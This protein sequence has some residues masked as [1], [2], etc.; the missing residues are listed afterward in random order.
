M[1]ISS[2]RKFSGRTSPRPIGRWTCLGSVSW[3]ASKAFPTKLKNCTKDLK[4]GKRMPSAQSYASVSNRSEGLVAVNGRNCVLDAGHIRPRTHCLGCPHDSHN[5]YYGTDVGAGN[6]GSPGFRVSLSGLFGVLHV[7]G[8][9]R[10]CQPRV[11]ARPA[12]HRTI[13]RKATQCLC[14]SGLCF[15]LAARG[16]PDFARRIEIDRGDGQPDDDVR[17]DVG[18]H[19]GRH[20]AGS[21][22]GDIG[23]GIVAR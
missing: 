3:L 23:D 11:P 12:I 1:C 13:L 21:D 10:L 5:I 20:Q 14:A 17:P 8:A 2:S 22:D 15:V 18:P 16:F 7:P 19:I 6:G 9:A 4:R